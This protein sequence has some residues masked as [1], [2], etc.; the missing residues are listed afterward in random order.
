MKALIA[1]ADSSCSRPMIPGDEL[2]LIQR[3]I[4]LS[5]AARLDGPSEPQELRKLVRSQLV[6]ADTG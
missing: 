3:L 2:L 6:V 1:W 5:R 4:S